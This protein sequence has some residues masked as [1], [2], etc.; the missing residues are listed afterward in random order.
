MSNRKIYCKQK[1]MVINMKKSSNIVWGIVLVLLGVVLG[2]NAMDITDINLFFDGWWT[3]FIIVPSIVGLVNGHDRT[4]S[5]ICL[6]IGVFLLL[7]CQGLLDFSQLWRLA[8]PA[9]IIL[10][11]LKMLLGNSFNNKSDEIA[12]KI[13]QDGKQ[14]HESCGIFSGQDIS[15]GGEEFHGAELSA[16]FGGVKCDLRGSI[17]E[18]DCV[19][20]ASSIF[21]G[22]TLIVPENVNVKVRSN[23]LF[24]GVSDKRKQR[25][26]NYTV[27]I[28][29]SAMCMFGGVDIK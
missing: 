1:G 6:F 25:D 13:K 12:K 28:Y 4:G 11:G 14:L 24:G 27:T 3:L 22:I 16:V 29:L 10:I 8:V 2:L 19:I 20:N 21:G 26:N 18:N 23:S 7:C 17:I 5:L 15:F 9:I